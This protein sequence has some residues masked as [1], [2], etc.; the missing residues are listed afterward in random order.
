[1]INELIVVKVANAT[2]L[3]HV[4]VVVVEESDQTFYEGRPNLQDSA[5]VEPGALFSIDAKSTLNFLDKFLA[6]FSRQRWN[7]RLFW[8]LVEVFQFSFEEDFESWLCQ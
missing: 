2:K 3:K 7:L 5:I 1:M 8:G 4:L 6:D